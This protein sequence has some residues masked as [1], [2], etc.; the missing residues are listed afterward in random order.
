[1]KPH[2]R[3][4]ISPAELK[5]LKTQIR[6]GPGRKIADAL[7]RK[8][9]ILA[10]ETASALDDQILNYD[11]GNRYVWALPDFGMIAQIDGNTAAVAAAIQITKACDSSKALFIGPRL[12][13]HRLLAPKPHRSDRH[14]EY[15]E[16][17][18]RSK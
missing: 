3:L 2:P 1:M 9:D 14:S 5:R 18:D 16:Q 4:F 11:R 8:V 13:R 7:R 12:S 15:G 10:K 17:K 6:T